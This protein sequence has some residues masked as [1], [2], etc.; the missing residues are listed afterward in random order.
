MISRL[1]MASRTCKE[2]LERMSEAQEEAV[3]CAGK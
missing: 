2:G 3:S 1:E